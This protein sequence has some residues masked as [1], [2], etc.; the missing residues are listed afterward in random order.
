[1]TSLVCALALALLGCAASAGANPAFVVSRVSDGDTLWVRPD[2]DR[3]KPV[4]LRLQG[5]DAPE[6]CQ[7]W[8]TQA[9]AALNGRALGQRVQVQGRASDDFGRLLVELRLERG[10]ADI[11]AWMVGQGHAWSP[12]FR[13]HPAAY[14]RQE[15]EARAARRGLFANPDAE[16]PRLFRKRHGPC[17]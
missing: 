16:P 3:R 14:A 1:M 8:G 6:R 15:R 5:I 12:R 2:G 10:G 7:P 13:H 17:E 4:K 11:G 9:T